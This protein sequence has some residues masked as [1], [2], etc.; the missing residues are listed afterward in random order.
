MTQAQ[1]P[2]NPLIDAARGREIQPYVLRLADTL[3]AGNIA[4][5]HRFRAASE[6]RRLHARVQEL[7]AE[8]V[9]RMA[10]NERMA[11]RIAELEAQSQCN[12]KTASSLSACRV[13]ALGTA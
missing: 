7:G 4:A 6:L 13:D 11:E 3:E 1:Q 5:Q 8:R 10:Q 12:T 2:D 9:T